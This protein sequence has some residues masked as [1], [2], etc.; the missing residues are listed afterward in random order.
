MYPNLDVHHP[1]TWMVWLRTAL[2]HTITSSITTGNYYR[3]KLKLCSIATSTQRGWWFWTVGI[4][5]GRPKTNHMLWVMIKMYL[6]QTHFDFV[7]D[8]CFIILKASKF[9]DFNSFPTFA[10][11]FKRESQEKLEDWCVPNQ[12]ESQNDS[13]LFYFIMGCNG[14]HI[15]VDFPLVNPMPNQWTAARLGHGRNRHIKILKQLLSLYN[16]EIIGNL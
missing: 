10:K 9:Q 5:A 14:L 1:T 12:S 3:V 2:S 13:K 8:Y 15:T 4:F 16:M 11:L 6:K 7:S